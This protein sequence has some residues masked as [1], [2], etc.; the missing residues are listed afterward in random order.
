MCICEFLAALQNLFITVLLGKQSEM[1]QPTNYK[2]SNYGLDNKLRH[3]FWEIITQR[4]SMEVEQ[5]SDGA[6]HPLEQCVIYGWSSL[7][8]VHNG[9]THPHQ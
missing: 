2:M 7:Q 4:K 6:A 1:S 9:I 5:V 8:L 3:I